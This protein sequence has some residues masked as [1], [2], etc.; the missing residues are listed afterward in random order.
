MK[1]I[2]PI[3]VETCCICGEQ[4]NKEKMEK[5][6]SGKSVQYLC[7]ECYAS[8]NRQLDSLLARRWSRFRTSGA[9]HRN[10][11]RDGKNDD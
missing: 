5:L 2:R 6:C 9:T 10:N 3:E 7:P 8:G 11:E 1:R 4:F